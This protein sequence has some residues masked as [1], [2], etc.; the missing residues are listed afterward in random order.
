M[1]L[2]FEN[3]HAFIIGASSDKLHSST[4]EFFDILRIHFIPMTMAFIN[5]CDIAIQLFF[6]KFDQRKFYLIGRTS[7]YLLITLAS[8]TNRVVRRPNLIV[9]RNIGHRSSA[10]SLCCSMITSHNAWIMFGHFNHLTS[11]AQKRDRVKVLLYCTTWCS[12]FSNSAEL[13]SAYFN[14]CRANSIT[15]HCKPRQIPRYGLS[16]VRAHS[17]AAIIPSV[18]REPKPPGTSTPLR[19]RKTLR[20]WMI[21]IGFYWF[22]VRC[23]V[24]ARLHDIS[25]DLLFAYSI[26]GLSLEQ[27]MI[28]RWIG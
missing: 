22:T 1:I 24:V 2:Q 28:E 3:F 15:A 12:Q 7:S 6:S 18:P 13:A 10:A 25:R 8:V 23:R 4:F 27:T 11:P 26:Q 20:L 16:L 21:F 19:R 5:G 14:T 17:I 9:P